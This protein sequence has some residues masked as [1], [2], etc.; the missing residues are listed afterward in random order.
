[1][2]IYIFIYLYNYS[3]FTNSRGVILCTSANRTVRRRGEE[4][5]ERENETEKKCSVHTV[6]N[7]SRI[8][9]VKRYITIVIHLREMDDNR[10]LFII[11]GV[12]GARGHECLH[13]LCYRWRTA[14]CWSMKGSVARLRTYSWRITRRSRLRSV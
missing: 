9:N 4:E 7:S 6:Y 8:R 13:V 5:K 2:N 10:A 12:N 1:M 14:T 11:V 3:S